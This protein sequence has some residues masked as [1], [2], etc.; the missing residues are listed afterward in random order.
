MTKLLPRFWCTR[1]AVARRG[2]CAEKVSADTAGLPGGQGRLGHRAPDPGSWHPRWRPSGEPPASVALEGG[3][4]GGGRWLQA[5]QGRPA[6]LG[7]PRLPRG[8]PDGE[9]GRRASGLQAP[10]GRHR[11][12]RESLS[13]LESG[14]WVPSEGGRPPRRRGARGRRRGPGR[15]GLRCG[16]PGPLPTAG[17][18]CGVAAS[19]RRIVA[20]E[21]PMICQ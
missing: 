17:E 10:R 6:G 12:G 2:C 13:Q 11:S 8:S 1:R 18:G 20:S 15:W 21:D 7:A 9:G 4:A 19:S 3:S 5:P 16:V 14:R